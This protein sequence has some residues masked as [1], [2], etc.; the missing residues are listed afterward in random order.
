MKTLHPGAALF[1]C[2]AA[3]FLLLLPARADAYAWMIRHDYAGCNQ[4]HADPSGGSLLTLYGRAQ[5]ELL[6]R[7]R[8]GASEEEAGKMAGFLFGVFDLPE[9]LLLGGDVRA[10]E[11]WTFPEQG[12]TTSQFVWMQSDV[13]GQVTAGRVRANG[14]IGY[15]HEGALPAAITHNRVDNLVSRAHWIGV[16]IGTDR[17]WLLRGGRMNLPFGIRFV[18][19]TLGVRQVT[20]T[21][22]NDQQQHGISL[23]YNGDRIRGEIMAVLGNFQMHPDMYRSRGGVGYI[24]IMAKQRLALG[25]SGLVLHAERDLFLAGPAWRQAYALSVRYSPALALVLLGEGDLL[26]QSQ[27]NGVDDTGYASVLQADWEVTQGVHLALTGEA[28]NAAP[29]RTDSTYSV[30]GSANWFFAPHA[31]VRLDIIDQLIP[32]GT[33]HVNAISVVPQLHVFL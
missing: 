25:L 12:A 19:H 15:A 4:C 23:A 11:V 27:P 6:L 22:I 26:F 17:E 8:Y 9:S 30:W 21:D 1:A 33:T 3:L 5:G 29:K 28:F 10:L 16:D 24:E 18:E 20:R 7:T 2:V 32:T 31:D 13:Q 14:S